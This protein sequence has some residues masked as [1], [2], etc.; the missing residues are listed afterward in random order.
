MKQKKLGMFG[1]IVI[2]IAT[3]VALGFLFAKCGAAGD[4]AMRV[5]KTFNVLFAQLLKFIVPLLILG[6]VTPAI[7]DAG[8]GAGKMLVSVM[9]GAYLSTCAA[10]IFAYFASGSLLPLYVAKGAVAFAGEGTA[11]LPYVDIKLPPVC[12]VLTALAL[13]FMTGVGIVAT[14]ASAFR[15]AV[16]EFSE[17]VRLTIMKVIIPGLPVY[18]M[19]MICEMTA[20]GK[21]GVMAGTMVK[22]IGTG[23]SLSVVFLVL[24]YI[25]AGAVAGKNPFKCLWNMAPAYLTGFSIA[26]SSAVI[27][28]TLDCCAKNGI[29][30]E[31]RN[32]TVPLC[33]NV[34]MVGSAIKMVTSTVAVVIIFGL[35][36]SFAQFLHFAFMFAVAAVAAP[37]VMCGVL[38]ASVGFLDSILGLTPEQTS[39]MMAFYMA[40]DGYGPAANVTGDGAIALVADRFWGKREA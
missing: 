38:M 31:I 14:G 21:I 19:T 18:I 17:I 28:V 30:K 5:L 1:R 9:V 24:L 4:V 20:S 2:A 3:G 7:A 8:K 16:D 29:S 39:I 32:F 13:S 36:V 23:W 34:H 22:V 10:S 27:P 26:S 6:F 12:D 15:R 25:A 33:A 40:L 11:F 35:D 37:G